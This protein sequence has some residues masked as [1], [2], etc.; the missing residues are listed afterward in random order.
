MVIRRQR[1]EADNDDESTT[2]SEMRE[3]DLIEEIRDVIV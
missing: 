3:D 1:V 2:G